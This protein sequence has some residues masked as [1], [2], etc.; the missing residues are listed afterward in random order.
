M[1]AREQRRQTHERLLR[2]PEGDEDAN[3]AA[4][5]SGGWRL[6][7]PQRNPSANA[8]VP[9]VSGSLRNSLDG[10][11]PITFNRNLPA[12][13]ALDSVYCLAARS[14]SDSPIPLGRGELGIEQIDFAEYQG[15]SMKFACLVYQDE[16]SLDALSEAEQLA[17]IVAECG[18]ASAWAE[19][20]QQGGRHVFS[21]GLQSARTARTVRNRNGKLTIT[22][23]P[24]AETKEILGGFTVIEVRDTHEALR[25][26]SK[27]PALLTSVELR[28]LMEP[29]AEL[30]DPVDRKIA[31]AI[32]QSSQ[33]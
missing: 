22:D 9:G 8:K 14:D 15:G 33:P 18:A 6:G 25:L 20:L 10:T 2:W 7:F 19:E 11:R 4:A 26:V 31:A 17:A 29:D 12:D 28:L 32:R 13:I 27:F 30:T 21:A 24:F 5:F 1:Y 16:T 3:L 23:R